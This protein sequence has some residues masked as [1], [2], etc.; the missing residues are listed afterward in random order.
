MYL[1]YVQVSF[2]GRSKRA[3][4]IDFAP[5]GEYNSFVNLEGGCIHAAFTKKETI[6]NRRTDP[7]QNDTFHPAGYGYELFT[8]VL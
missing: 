1:A 3:F 7:Q 2:Q 5:D 6:H 4:A 8:Y